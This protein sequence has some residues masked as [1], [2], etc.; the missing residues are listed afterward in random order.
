MPSTQ[1]I[2]TNVATLDEL[3]EASIALNVNLYACEMSGIILGHDKD[4]YLPEIKE[5]LGV[6]KFLEISQDGQTLFI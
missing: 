6:A 2:P 3:I 5:I 1:M 4:T